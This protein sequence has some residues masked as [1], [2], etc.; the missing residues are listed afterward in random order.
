MQEAEMQTVEVGREICWVW[1]QR[2]E[3]EEHYKMRGS[4]ADWWTSSLLPAF[5][6]L[7]HERN[8]ACFRLNVILWVYIYA[9]FEHR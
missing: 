6:S 5:N 1:T 9:A 2:Q 7:P 3:T 4:S 8:C